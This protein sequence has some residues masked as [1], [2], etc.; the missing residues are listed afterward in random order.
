[1]TETA[2][3]VLATGDGWHLRLARE[4]DNA[5]LCALFARIHMPGELDICQERDPDFFALRRLHLGE[6]LTAVGVDDEG[7]LVGCGVIVVLPGWLRGEPVQT[8]YLADLRVAPGFR[9]GLNL[10]R[11]YA[12]IMDHVREQHGAELFTTVIFDG[13][14]RARRALTGGGE[15]RAGQPVY[16]PMTPFEMISVQFTLPKPAPARHV[17]RATGADK[18]E[19]LDFLVRQQHS[20][21]LG[22]RTDPERLMQRMAAWPGFSYG[23]FLIARARPGGRITG[24]LAPWD[25]RAVKRTRVLGYHGKMKLI[26]PAFDAAA[27]VLGF[28]RLPRAGDCFDFSFLTHLEVIDDDPAVMRDLLLAAYRDLRAEAPA[29][30]MSAF[31]P[32]GSPLAGAFAGF[33]LQRTPMTLYVVHPQGSRFA[34]VDFTTRHPGF[35]M[36]LS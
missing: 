1:M 2:A 7:H 31:V 35:E 32:R 12:R 34:N 26:K 5:E 30:F 20:R 11:A 10:A 24:C 27:T 6:A 13:N 23:A 36:A 4:S 9:G 29:H 33:T 21:V 25:T 17:A 16:R 14:E 8:G 3:D 22:E 15:R 18:D 19:L 28:P